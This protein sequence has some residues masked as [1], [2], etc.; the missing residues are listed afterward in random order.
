M[1]VNDQLIVIDT[2][3]CGPKGNHAAEQNCSA[4]FLSIQ[5]P[6]SI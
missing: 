1:D 5:N 3:F 6:Y 2:G 4:A